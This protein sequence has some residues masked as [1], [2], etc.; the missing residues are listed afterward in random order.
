MIF[1][2]YPQIIFK[3]SK[4][5]DGN[6]SLMKGKPDVAIKNRK[7]FLNKFDLSLDQI[8]CMFVEHEDKVVVV[9]KNSL[10]KGAF[11]PEDKI[12]SDGI[13][14]DQKELILM[15]ATGDCLPIGVYDP[16]KQVIALIHGSRKSLATKIFDYTVKILKTNFGS[17]IENLI[18]S[19][20]PSI[21]PCCYDI[22]LWSIAERKLRK[23]GIPQ[24]NIYNCQIC[25]YHTNQHFSH[26]RAKNK[27]QN[28]FRSATILGIRNVS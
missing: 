6:M 3:S 17:K 2:K 19:I 16:D 20:G 23:L 11:K 26:R 27:N 24:K 22:D 15:I 10:G 28:D 1:D 12:R 14:T 7:S 5:S 21:G 25:T 9:D 13:I 18:V 4:I 8:V